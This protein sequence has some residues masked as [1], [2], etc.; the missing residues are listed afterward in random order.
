MRDGVSHKL[1]LPQTVLEAT[2]ERISWIFDSF[3][4]VNV[5]VSGG[6][7]STVLFDLAYREAEKRNRKINLF[8][9]DQEAEYRSTIEV[10]RY[11]MHKPLVVPYWYQVPIRMT[12]ATSYEE[13]FL[14]A[15]EPGVEWMRE[16][17]DIAIHENTSGVERFYPFIDWFASQWEG[18]TAILVGL[19]ADESLSRYS[20][21]TRHPAIPGVNWSS[22]CKDDAIN[23]YPIYD[24]TFEDV[25]T[26]IGKEAVPYNRI[27]D[28]MYAKGIP[29][30][31]MRV[32][33]L[34]HEEAFRSLHTLQEFEPDTY[35]KLI[36]RLRGVPT[37][38]RYAKE[39]MVYDTRRLPPRFK[40]WRAYRDF[41]LDTFPTE[42]KAR[43]LERFARQ[44]ERESV[45]RQQVRQL[46]L[47]DWENNVPVAQH[48]ERENPLL[49]WMKIL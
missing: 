4:T 6:K 27:Y 20:A 23:F 19:R 18:D 11:M 32:S 42:R 36:V 7:D 15:W 12:N 22:K 21:V 47:N 43:F 2:S 16:K 34:I 14:Y 30:A 48:K 31:E 9:L 13:E 28:W 26:Y 40:T 49:K 3:A 24:W 33:N 38:A 39:D 5:S 37:A 1:Y 8:F 44:T 10:M 29:Q 41:L 35:D 46:L 25:W 45:Y 17:E